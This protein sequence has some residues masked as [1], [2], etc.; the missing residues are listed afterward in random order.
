MRIIYEV[1]VYVASCSLAVAMLGHRAWFHVRGT[2]F[3]ER[4]VLYVESV[5][6][7]KRAIVEATSMSPSSTTGDIEWPAFY[8]EDVIVRSELYHG[9][10][11]PI[12]QVDK[13]RRELRVADGWGGENGV[14]RERIHE[15]VSER[16]IQVGF[17]DTNIQDDKYALR[18]PLSEYT[19]IISYNY[20]EISILVAIF[21]CIL[22]AKCS[23]ISRRLNRL[24]KTND[25]NYETP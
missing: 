2:E 9:L 20:A 14:L 4:S 5:H 1:F 24:V 10:V 22:G 6:E 11:G 18:M 23:F 21:V 3:V 17:I 12:L 7:G 15:W 19:T 16:G 13:R 8:V 25:M